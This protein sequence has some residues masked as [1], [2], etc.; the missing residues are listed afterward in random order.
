MKKKNN[1]KN[2]W[3]DSRLYFVLV[4][5]ILSAALLIQ[6]FLIH[7]LPMKYFIAL[8]A[9]LLV[10][11]LLMWALQY[12]KGIN[13]LNRTL[14]KIMIVLLSGLLIFANVYV[15]IGGNTLGAI[16]GQS[17]LVTEISVV[18]MKEDQAET[19]TDLKND[20]FGVLSVMDQENTTYAVQ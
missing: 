1:R 13:K 15:F 5:T 20:S 11:L 7:I 6:L 8:I 10:L 9:V 3:K 12:G 17:D 16:T 2:I 4:Q 18:V 19:I 14:G